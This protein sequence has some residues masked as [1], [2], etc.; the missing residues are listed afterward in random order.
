MTYG[1]DLPVKG[2]DQLLMQ[3]L[4]ALDNLE[5][6]YNAIRVTLVAGSTGAAVANRQAIQT[7]LL[8][9][10]PT[11]L[12][13]PGT[14]YIDNTLFLDSN[15][16]VVID[17]GCKISS[18]GTSR[19]SL[20]TTSNVCWNSNGLPGVALIAAST[21]ITE[22]VGVIRLALGPVRL[23]FTAP[24]DTE[25]VLVDV[26]GATSG[27][28]RFELTSANGKKLAVAVFVAGLTGASS[29]SIRI[30]ASEGLTSVTWNRVSNVTTVTEI[31]H[32]RQ[33]GDAVFT[34]GT[35]FA[36]NIYI[37]TIVSG[38]SWT[39]TDSRGNSSGS[40][41]VFGK[42]DVYIEGSGT[43]DYGMAL[44]VGVRSIQDTNTIVCLGLSHFGINGL[45]LE[46]GY[47][48][49]VLG[50][51]ITNFNIN[52]RG[53]SDNPTSSTAIVQLNGKARHGFISVTGKSTDTAMALIGGDYPTQTLL[54]PNDQGG[55][56][57]DDIEL[58]ASDGVDSNYEA[59]RLAGAAG[60]WY[61]NIRCYNIR[62]HVT[63]IADAIISSAIDSGI[64]LGTE[65]NISG[66]LVDGVFPSKVG[67]TNCPIVSLSGGGA[68]ISTGVILRRLELAYPVDADGFA[69]VQIDSGSWQDITVEDCY[70]R[71]PTWQGNLVGL[72]NGVTNRIYS[73][74]IRNNRLRINNALKNT[75]WRSALFITNNPNVICDMLT[76][77][78]N[79]VEDV[80]SGGTLASTAVYNQGNI[81]R[82]FINR[83]RCIGTLDLL[84]YFSGYDG[85]SLHI[86]NIFMNGPSFV[87][88]IDAAVTE[89][90][91]GGITTTVT[92]TDV[93]RIGYSSFTARIRSLGGMPPTP[94]S[95]KHVNIAAGS[96]N[97]PDV[98]GADIRV[99]IA[100]LA[101]IRGN[102]VRNQANGD[103]C[104]YNSAGTW[105]A[106]V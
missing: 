9:G 98:N 43:L 72:V 61:R 81:Y 75:S 77:E 41:Q 35:S 21:E 11:I 8:S 40:G 92:L 64:Y 2:P 102:L 12:A 18:V 86:T 62:H 3:R 106:I 84:H 19:Y 91:F 52:V 37:N 78:D 99:D 23:A 38:V 95:G 59:V 58:R 67:T 17:A 94:S 90:Q 29:V 44:G 51:C 69:A 63:A 45:S 15:S 96:A 89:I 13:T 85:A 82:S 30:G 79:T 7:A 60:L 48:Y 24:G 42:H 65:T 1:K 68:S 83:I 57:F 100:A 33:S 34:T 74:V 88:R 53:Y 66:L 5:D 101:A 31:G 97:S 87:C 76:M 49:G 28:A 73:L 104:M 6:I 14:C 26:S 71:N 93:V 55:L 50:Q 36:A 105:A 25:G 56:D 46:D 32:T 39:F 70:Q 103:V 4:L 80:S 10:L 54:F 16:R 27:A 22:G 47:K 20:F